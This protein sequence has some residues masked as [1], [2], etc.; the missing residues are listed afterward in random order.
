MKRR[1]VFTVTGR[2]Q[3]EPE[4]QDIPGNPL[5]DGDSLL[6]TC[7]GC[8]SDRVCYWYQDRWLCK[9]PDRCWKARK[10]KGKK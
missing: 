8:G 4:M 2:K 7:N 6:T 10:K 1:N 5:R 3:S 9:G